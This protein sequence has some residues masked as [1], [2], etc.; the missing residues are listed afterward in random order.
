MR[1]GGGATLVALANAAMSSL[2]L[3]VLSDIDTIRILVFISLAALMF[4]CLHERRNLLFLART[5]ILGA[6]G[7]FPIVVKMWRGP[8]ALFSAYEPST[9]AFEITV[10][11]Y[12]AASFALLSS[13]VGFDFAR[14]HRPT[15]SSLP[16]DAPASSY[17]KLAALL[18]VCMAVFSS[19]MFV[20]GY[21]ESVLSAGYGAERGGKGLPF[22]SVGI[23]GSMG[24]FALYVAGLKGQVPHW[25][26]LVAAV[27][28]LFIIYSQLLMGVRQD[29][30]STLFGL[31]ILYGVVQ[32]RELQL[33]VSYLP[34]MAVGYIFFEVWGF[35]R[36]AL[37]DGVPISSFITLTF[38]AVGSG[39]AVKLGTISPIATTFSNTVFLVQQ[40]VIEHSLGRSYWEWL[41]RIPPEALYPDR[42]KDYALMFEDLGLMSGGGFFELAEVYMNFGLLGALVIP[43]II[44][45]VLGR[46]FYFVLRQQTML[47]Y[48][49]LFAFLAV[50]LRG[51]WYQTFAFFRAEMV[52]L[53]AYFVCVALVQFLKLIGRH[54][55][56]SV[57]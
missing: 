45:Y 38:A 31:V 34:V 7:Y 25:K 44:S 27:G 35:A 37:A 53:I 57:T 13:H 55:R 28:A 2:A 51:T 24:M 46:V 54:E 17:W 48:F 47:S 8:D 36:E 18:G 4:L 19:V 29:A 23:L 10:I 56:A 42:P 12:V 3:L 22:G 14:R 16:S 21:G 11:M 5:F 49:V 15:S 40:G 43:G 32:G 1:E 20:R 39:E 9:Q 30:M 52:C 50:F 6:I 33:R 41:L 26:L